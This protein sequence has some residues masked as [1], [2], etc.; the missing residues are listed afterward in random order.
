[1]NI[2]Q[3]EFELSTKNYCSRQLT[4]ARE[5]LTPYFY[6]FYKNFPKAASDTRSS[7]IQYI[8]CDGLNYPVKESHHHLQYREPEV[9]CFLVSLNATLLVTKVG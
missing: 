8:V 5:T 3:I 7:Y 2:I 4:L 1:M 9:A 6:S